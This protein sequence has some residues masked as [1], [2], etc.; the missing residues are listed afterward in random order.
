MMKKLSLAKRWVILCVAL[1][2]VLAGP[3]VHAQTQKLRKINICLP[4]TRRW[5]RIFSDR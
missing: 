2:F 1:N 3:M 4:D 5:V